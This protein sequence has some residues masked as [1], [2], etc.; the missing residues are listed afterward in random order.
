MTKT[1]ISKIKKTIQQSCN[2]LGYKI[3]PFDKDGI[4]PHQ[5]PSDMDPDF[6]EE[7]YKKCKNFSMTSIERM[8]ALYKSVQYIIN[9][10]IPGDFVECGVWKGGSAM[11]IA[12]TLLKLNDTKRK[13]F[14]Y[15]TFEGMPPPTQQ[16]RL[17]GGGISAMKIWKREQKRSNNTWCLSSMTEVKNNLLSTGYP[18]NKLVFVK[19]KVEN[20]IPKIIPTK[21]ALLRL[22]TD[23]YASTRHEVPHLYPLISNNGVLIIDDYGF[24]TGSQKAIDEYLQKNKLP[25]LLNRIDCTGRI[26]IKTQTRIMK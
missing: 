11:V 19:G 22:D 15:D 9:A 23:W 21:I 25:I 5:Y 7:I 17:V 10:N 14:L 2:I 4:P 20:T 3:I 12:L 1:I 26:A 24:F 18:S 13:I 16:D 6:Y 8:Y